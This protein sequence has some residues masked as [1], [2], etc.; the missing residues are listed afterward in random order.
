MTLTPEM[1]EYL[2]ENITFFIKEGFE[3]I[4]T[5]PDFF[6][7]KWEQWHLVKIEEQ[8]YKIYGYCRDISTEPQISLLDQTSY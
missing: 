7:K 5:V 1:V 8:L 6:D 2:Y 3:M 4:V